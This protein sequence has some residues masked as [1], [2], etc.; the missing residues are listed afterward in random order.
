[1]IT[2]ALIP[3]KRF[4][5]G[6]SRL[7][8]VLSPA[9]LEAVNRH[10]FKKTLATVKDSGVFNRVMVISEDPEVL[11]W[12]S[13]QCCYALPE[14]HTGDLNSALMQALDAI[15]RQG[16]GSV[17]MI[18]TDLPLLSASDLRILEGLVPEKNGLL[19]VPDH[20]M[21]GTNA[22]FVTEP[23]LMPTAFGANSFALHLALAEERGLRQVIHLSSNIQRDLDTPEDL[24]FFGDSLYQKPIIN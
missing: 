7:H 15:V 13:D 20:Q 16:G 9:E 18:P 3:V 11:L 2:W 1:V 21:T 14:E 12:V 10:L 19:I 23:K 5:L 22:L 8:E 24:A 17:L 4:N 6:K